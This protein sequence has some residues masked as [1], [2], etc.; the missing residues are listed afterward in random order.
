MEATVVES[1]HSLDYGPPAQIQGNLVLEVSVRVGN[2]CYHLGNGL[3]VTTA[4]GL[5]IFVVAAAYWEVSK[6]S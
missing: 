6:C 5:R 3:A 2:V 4:M 1:S